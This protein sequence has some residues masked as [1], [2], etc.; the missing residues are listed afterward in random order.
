MSSLRDL[1]EFIRKV[2]DLGEC[3]LIEGADWN[4]EIGTLNAWQTSL[5]NSPMLLFDKIKGYPAGYRVLANLFATDKRTALALGLPLD[6]KGVDLVKAWREKM[7]GGIKPIPPVEVKTGPVK[8]NIQ[9]GEEVDLFKFPTP[10]WNEFDGG[11]YIGTGNLVITRDPDEG[12]VNLG[13]Y[14]V[15]IHEKNIATIYMS[16]GRHGDIMRRKY[17]AK[18]KSCPAIVTC[19]QEP[20]LFAPAHLSIPWGMSE[21]DYTGWMKGEPVEV[22]KG[23]ITDLPIPATAEIALEGEI[24]PPEVDS[25]EEGPFGEWTGYY[26]SAE[27]PEPTFRV[28]AVL[29]R[30]DPIIQGN[31]PTIPYKFALGPNLRRAG[32]IWDE[33]DRHL[34]GVKGVWVLDEAQGPSIA[35]VSIKQMYPGHAKQAAMVTAGNSAVAYL[36][37]WIIIVDDDIDPS[38]ITDLLWCLGT[39]TYPENVEVL[40][41]CWGSLLDPTLPPEKRRTGDTTHSTGIIIACKPYH[42]IDKFPRSIKVNPKLIEEAKRKWGKYFE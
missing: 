23:V 11:R 41:E 40:K 21:Y 19:G 20:M 2:Q 35:V 30:N 7:K 24:M 33:L 4:L 31:P 6:V 39:R 29:H 27:R 25:H 36:C 10:K 9:V 17:W 16:P 42:W 3:K 15:Q 32:M 18:G 12:W 38:N 37:R 5:P 14:R 28:K 22:T 26:G 1:R 13:T 8:E 34:P